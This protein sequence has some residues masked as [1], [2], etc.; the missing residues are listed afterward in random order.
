MKAVFM[1]G[2][3][4][5]LAGVYKTVREKL[6]GELEFIAPITSALQLEE[7][8]EEIRNVEV[9]FSTWGMLSIDE[10]TIRKYFVNLRA[11]F[12]ASSSPSPR[13]YSR[14]RDI[15]RDSGGT[16]TLNGRTARP[17]DTSPETSAI[18]S[19]SSASE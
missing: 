2:D 18:R 3:E 7:R 13:S 10:D 14:T 17:A 1:T 6:T 16:P 11:V 9:I 5:N 12:Y 8:K 4:R 15:I 19:G